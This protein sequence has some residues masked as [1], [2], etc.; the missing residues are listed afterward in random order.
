MKNTETELIPEGIKAYLKIMNKNVLPNYKQKNGEPYDC[1]TI[2]KNIKHL[3]E[4]HGIEAK[5]IRYDSKEWIGNKEM[6]N[7]RLFPK[8]IE[9][10]TKGWEYHDVCLANNKILDPILGM[11]IEAKNYSQI[12]FEREVG[13]KEINYENKK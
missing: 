8:Y 2:A 12:L 7:E 10:I 6:N 3:C 13:V 5:I 4:S 11:P 1:R 9:G